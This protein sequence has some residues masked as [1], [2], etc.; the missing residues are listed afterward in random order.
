LLTTP[1]KGEA[2]KAK[3]ATLY[4]PPGQPA[5]VVYSKIHLSDVEVDGA[6]PVRESDHFWPGEKAETWQILVWRFGLS[7]CFDFRFA[8]LYAHYAGVLDAILIPSAFLVPT[9]EAHW[10]VLIRARVI[11]NQAFVIAPAQ[12]GAH[13]SE[14]GA[15][16]KTYGHSMVVDPWGRVLLDESG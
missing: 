2:G 11:E 14:T 3:N 6:P 10:N 13:R 15:V 12:T 5:K 7:I 9:G 4:W 16:R 1:I 8:E